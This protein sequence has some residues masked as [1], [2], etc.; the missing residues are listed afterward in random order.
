MFR[1]K[2]SWSQQSFQEILR[3]SIIT[4]IGYRVYILC[5][6]R[7]STAADEYVFKVE[8]RCRVSSAPQMAT[9]FV[10]RATLSLVRDVNVSPGMRCV[11]L[12]DYSLIRLVTGP[13]NTSVVPLEDASICGH[14]LKELE[15]QVIR[16]RVVV[17]KDKHTE[18]R[19]INY[20]F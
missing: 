2:C 8:Q 17:E 5:F 4:G 19:L 6:W 3:I 9:Q 13:C 7:S 18:I 12:P 1:G 10:P 15:K 14:V 11:T 16:D 20:S